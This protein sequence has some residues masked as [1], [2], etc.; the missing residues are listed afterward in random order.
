MPLI[1]KLKTMRVLLIDDN[2]W[3]R[4]SLEYYFKKKAFSFLALEDAE[5]ALE[6]LK[7]EAFDIIICDYKLPGINGLAFFKLSEKLRPRTMK[8]LITAYS[9]KKVFA[10]AKRMGIDDFLQKPLTIKEL[11]KSFTRVIENRAK[12][13]QKPLKNGP[14]LNDV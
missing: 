6:R 4:N 1:E 13:R 14:N 9:S 11:E 8:V 10:K 3:I 2:K 5:S 7:N 12:I